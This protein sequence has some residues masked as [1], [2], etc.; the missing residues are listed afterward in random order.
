MTNA[1]Q[2]SVSPNLRESDKLTDRKRADI[3]KAAIACFSENGF[4]NTSMDAIASQAN[5]S[6]R[7]VYNHFSSKDKLFMAI[8]N[9]LKENALQ[10]VPFVYDRKESLG[11]QLG[12]FCQRIIDFQCQ[13]DSRALA[14]VLISRFIRAPQLGH[15]MFGNG[16]V[17]ELSL[18][19]WIVLAQ[20]DKRLG[21]FDTAIGA[22]QLLAMLEGFCVWPQLILGAP[23][24]NETQRKRI[25]E[26]I[27]NMFL[28]TYGSKAQ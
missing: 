12:R 3:L 19:Q 24:P 16:K 18:T 20:K 15:E 28:N 14:R 13:T 9:E 4:D 17:F 25:V 5:V 21:N 8:V 22:R 23:N 27:V 7:T 1:K 6:K 2:S 10:A 26:S 11:T